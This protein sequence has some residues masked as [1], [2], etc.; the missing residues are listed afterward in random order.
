MIACKL[1]EWSQNTLLLYGVKT[2]N[3]TNVDEMKQVAINSIFIATS[4]LP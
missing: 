1:F 3:Q 2:I 4:Y